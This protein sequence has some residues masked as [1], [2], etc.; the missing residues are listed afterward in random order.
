MKTRV[1][2]IR[3]TVDGDTVWQ[4]GSVHHVDDATLRRLVDLGAVEIKAEPAAPE[5][6]AVQAA[7]QNKRRGRP[8]KV[9]P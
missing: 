6:K 5:N 7:P 8:R 9:Q 1:Q 3:R 4:G 2:I